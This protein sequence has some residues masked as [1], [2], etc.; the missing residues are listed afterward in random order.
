MLFAT[1]HDKKF[2]GQMKLCIFA[3]KFEVLLLQTNVSVNDGIVSLR[4]SSALSRHKF[5]DG[6]SI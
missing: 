3:M 1:K 4:K 6:G 2:Y 5:L